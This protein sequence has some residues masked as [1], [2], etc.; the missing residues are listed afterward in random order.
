MQPDII[1]IIL[2]LITFVMAVIV[3]RNFGGGLKAH[4]KREIIHLFLDNI[5][6]IICHSVARPKHSAQPSL[7]FGRTVHKRQQSA[8]LGYNPNRMSID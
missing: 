1:S 2:L 7:A 8:P 6:P 5:S 3:M 4:S